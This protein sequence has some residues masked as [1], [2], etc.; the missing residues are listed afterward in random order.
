MSDDLKPIPPSTSLTAYYD[1][2]CPVC[3]REIDWY[4]GQTGESVLY[5]DVASG[6]ENPAPD[7][8]RQAALARFHVRRADGTL[9]SGAAAFLALW[10]QTGRLA[11]LVPV[12]S[13]PVIL[14]MLDA[15]YVA[16]LGIRRVWRR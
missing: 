2:G 5:C 15:G 16:F 4:R 3:R 7:L 13:Q 14:R 8:D 6:I 10:G 9:V 12:L 1:G 11:W